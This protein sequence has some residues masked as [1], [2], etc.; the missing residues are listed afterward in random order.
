MEIKKK[1]WE[2]LTPFNKKVFYTLIMAGFV[3][4]ALIL[5]VPIY[6]LQVF[7]RVLTSQSLDTLFLISMIVLFLLI[8]QSILDILKNRYLHQKSAKLDALISS[9]FYQRLTISNGKN[10]ASLQDVR[11][12]KSFMTSPAFLLAFDMIWAPLFLLVM[13]L[14]HPVVGFV[15]LSAVLLVGGFSLY[16]YRSK[17]QQHADSQV[18][19]S[20]CRFASEQ[21]TT[22]RDNIQAQYLADGLN[23]QFQHMTAERVWFDQQLGLTSTTLASIAKCLRFTLQMAI[24]AV[25]AWLVIENTMS[26]GGIIAGSILMSRVLQPFEQLAS[27]LQAWQHANA[28]NQR[29]C[30]Y[31][32]NLPQSNNT[33][34]FSDINGS[35]HIDNVS[36][37]PPKAKLPLLKNIRLKLEPGNRVMI[38]GANGS[39]KTALCQLLVGLSQPSS[40]SVRIDT[41]SLPQWDANQL[42]GVIGYVPQKFDF[43]PGTI[44]QNIAHFDQNINDSDVISAAKA[45]GIHQDIVRLEHG[46]NTPLGPTA[47]PISMGLAQA[48][49]IARALYYRP[50]LLIFDEANAHLDDIRLGAFKQLLLQQKQQGSAVVMISHQRELI[51]CVDW[52]VT[53][54]QGEIT[55]A[56]K[57]EQITAEQENKVREIKQA[58]SHG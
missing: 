42:K 44:K 20:A 19:T 41:A 49:A 29:I 36:W 30:A 45:I 52:V 3:L 24:M 34:Q 35:L 25:G 55:T 58:V 22:Q 9:F 50:K 43:L 57:A 21:A 5:V 38:M 6:S 8:I 17:T 32:A 47:L 39:G 26:A 27:T 12:I 1:D 15:G 51:A 7:D 10:S 31:F 4:N 28:A 33:T 56:K 18:A 40:G 53:L 11:E 48:I 54:E 14:L 2:Q 46:Y 13:F 23:Q 37:Y 16:I